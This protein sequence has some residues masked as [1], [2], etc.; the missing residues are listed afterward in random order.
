MLLA[1]HGPVEQDALVSRDE[2]R[3][4]LLIDACPSQ[5]RL[6]GPL[7]PYGDLTEA[8]IVVI[9]AQH[10][11]CLVVQAFDLLVGLRCHVARIDVS[12]MRNDEGYGHGMARDGHR[13]SQQGIHL[14]SELP[15]VLGIETSGERRRAH[16]AER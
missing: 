15:R 10:D 16:F 4:Q 9:H 2:G 5:G 3:G 1:V 13:L 6:E 12:R 11:D 8:G 14:R 7:C